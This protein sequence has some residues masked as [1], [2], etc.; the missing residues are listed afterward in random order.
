MIMNHTAHAAIAGRK[1][2]PSSRSRRAFIKRMGALG[3]GFVFLSGCQDEKIL[4]QNRAQTY[5]VELK[6]FFF[7]PLGLTLKRGDRVIWLEL[8]NVLGD[9]HT[10][11]AFHP[12]FDKPLR[13]PEAAEPWGSQFMFD[14]GETWERTFTAPGVHDYFCVPHE[15]MGM[16]GRILVEQ[17]TGPG[18]QPLNMGLSAAGQAT[19]PTVE[20]LLG[21]TGEV[22][23]F[24]G[25]LNAVVLSLRQEDRPQA[26]ER[27]Q[28]LSAEVE[29]LLLQFLKKV[30]ATERQTAQAE[31]EAF[32]QVLKTQSSLFEVVDAAERLK[33]LLEQLAYR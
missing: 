33:V 5:V 29:T 2:H 8:E 32:A 30:S 25:R 22:F 12:D 4:A 19:I 14:F 28:E 13:I 20:E 21:P 11:T 26:L 17:A 1:G 10:A 18:T 15:D 9:G 7:D 16:V 23:N 24:Q 31:I 6:D 27:W 3:T